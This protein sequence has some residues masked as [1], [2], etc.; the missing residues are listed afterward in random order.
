[1][2]LFLFAQEVK[3]HR[4]KYMESTRP[5]SRHE[6]VTF[7][8]AEVSHK[9]IHT[10]IWIHRS[11]DSHR[12]TET[13]SMFCKKCRNFLSLSCRLWCLQKSTF[14]SPDC[15]VLSTKFSHIIGNTS[16]VCLF[17]SISSDRSSLLK[18]QTLRGLQEW[19][20]PWPEPLWSLQARARWEELR[21]RTRNTSAPYLWEYDGRGKLPITGLTFWLYTQ[22][23]LCNTWMAVHVKE[24]IHLLVCALAANADRT[25]L[26]EDSQHCV[27]LTSKN[28]WL[29][30]SKCLIS[31]SVLNINI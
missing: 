23:R 8:P 10:F 2:F 12:T 20:W 9:H 17:F 16:H 7:H 28:T 22:H 13:C 26:H 11:Y 3:V 14:K 4:E 15:V 21:H 30:S 24:P 29:C 18:L 25:S 27:L 31:A 1:M 19:K 6:D 5:R